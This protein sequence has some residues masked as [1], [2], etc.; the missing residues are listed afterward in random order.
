MVYIFAAA[1]NMGWGPVS[2]VRHSSRHT[3]H[4]LESRRLTCPGLRVGDSHESTASLQC[5]TSKFHPLGAQPGCVQGHASDAIRDSLRGVFHLRKL[6]SHN[7]NTCLVDSRDKGSKYKDFFWLPIAN[8]TK[9]S[10][11]RMD[12][13]FGV[14]DFSNIEDVG[15]AAKQ[16]RNKEDALEVEHVHASK[17]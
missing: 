8:R 1:F 3:A 14:A 12:E 15:V 6:Q 4:F 13:L 10:L 17:V 9:I 7:G 16:A 11:E 2:W 5:C